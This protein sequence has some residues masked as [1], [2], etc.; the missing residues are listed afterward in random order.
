MPFRAIAFGLALAF[1]G[2]PAWAQKE[3][4][5]HYDD[6]Q[7]L[8]ARNKCKE[9]I[10]SLREAQKLRPRSAVETQTYGIE[11]IDYLPYY[12]EGLCRLRL[13]EYGTAIELLNR[14]ENQGAIK[15]KDRL[16]QD[17]L[18][19]RKQ[20]REEQENADRQQRARAAL[21][22]VRRLR[23]EAE[24][25]HKAG[26]LEE[27][28]VRLAEAQKAAEPLDLATQ[29]QVLDL[30]KRFRTEFNEKAEQAERAERIEKG[31]AQGRRLL[32]AGSP[33]EA[34]VHFENVIARDPGN[35]EALQGKAE[36]ERRIRA[37]STLQEMADAFGRGKALFESG[38]Y[39]QARVELAKADP[40][41]PQHRALAEDAQKRDEATQQQKELR[42]K[43]EALM[44]EAERLLTAR[45]FS[46][47]MVKLVSALELDPG[48]PKTKERLGLAERMTGDEIFEK[49]FPNQSPI[50]TFIEVPSAEVEGA[51][52]ALLGVAS[53]DR[54]L[55]RIQYRQ[56]DQVVAEQALAP[57]R[58]TGAFPRSFRIEHVFPL[59]AGENRLTVAAVDTRGVETAESF[60]VKRR[61]RFYERTA[62]W[63]SM[64]AGSLGLVGLGFA[65]Q[66]ARRRR[67]LRNRFNPY[68]AGAPVL[69]AEMFFGRE[70]L[71][72][73]IMNVLHHNSLM[74]TGERRIGKT[75][76]LYHLKRALENDQATDYQF[77]PVF[78]DL[79]GVPEESFFHTIMSDVVEGL[80]PAPETLAALRFKSQEDGYDGRD[81]SH[82][83]QRIIEEL[84]TRTP[85]QVKL[86]LLIDEVDV[87]NEYS[88]RINQRLRSIFMKTFSEH[89][90]AV[91]SG[92]GIKRVWTS[93]G[94]PWYNFFDEIELA[95]FTREEAEELI[96]EPVEGVFRYQ[97]EAVERILTMSQLKPYVIQKFCIHAV[98]RMLE[99]GR[100]MVTAGDIEAV[101]DT[102]LF[103]GRSPLPT[104]E[105]QRAS[106]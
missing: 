51:R 86:A 52:L 49:I 71:L 47:A 36:A 27:A 34:R 67:A 68:I 40:D 50:L 22:E 26:R 42:T 32:D 64:L 88:G 77:F 12:Q 102:V 80:R 73:R 60:A 85:R 37:L 7:K 1:A 91:M 46:E 103:E 31:L 95:A 54:G 97:P 98:N 57:D 90:V 59:E 76:F 48:N 20:A 38:Q 28:L 41:N 94:S 70:K 58:D 19:L 65:A 10:L 75:T 69:D 56:G 101:T 8:I 83:V 92:V 105:A 30:Q 18:R 23:R 66:R 3:W 25:A 39:A 21:E 104:A 100:M 84:K 78:T 89:L 61:L 35:P 82:D 33:A 9:A 96:R 2:T 44:A 72:A 63:P 6:A 5:A 74:I 13:G 99:E 11:F 55:T 29:Q 45:R 24:E 106:A 4:Y 62:F 81:F 17:L 16:Y 43:L 53:D 93:E 79:Q 15:K 14:E 87:L